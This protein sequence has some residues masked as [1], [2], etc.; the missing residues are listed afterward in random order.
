M[1][2]QRLIEVAGIAIVKSGKD[3]TGKSSSALAP[4]CFNAWTGWRKVYLQHVDGR[5]EM[6]RLWRGFP[7]AKNYRWYTPGGRRI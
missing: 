1:P 7:V 5:Q 3:F 6:H 2:V 4:R